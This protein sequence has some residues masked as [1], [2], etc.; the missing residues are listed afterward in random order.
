[1]AL[2]IRR[3][4]PGDEEIVRALA[5]RE[6]Y[7]PL[8][9][10]AARG[11]LSE[12]RNLLVVAFDGG[13]PVGLVLGY[14]LQRRHGPERS[15][16]VYDIG[17]EQRHRRR[18][19]GTQLMKHL[20]AAAQAEGAAEAFVLTDE[21]NPSAMRFYESLGGYRERNDDVMYDFRL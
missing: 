14:E 17:V 19:I 9:P 3:L 7:E 20:F 10:E 18:G 1:M 12:P 15:L 4:Q 13:E 6:R 16:F 8:S 21:S 2:E 11:L 5:D